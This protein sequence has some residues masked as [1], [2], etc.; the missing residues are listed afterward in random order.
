MISPK[1]ILVSNLSWASKSEEIALLTL[2]ELGIRYL[3]VAPLKIPGFTNYSDI[4]L[5]RNYK[6]FIFNN[7]GLKIYSVQAVLHRSG[8]SIFN[9][10]EE[11]KVLE[12]FIKI[13]VFSSE[14]GAKLLILGSPK[15]RILNENQSIEFT[16]DLVIKLI[17][18]SKMYDIKLLIEANPVQYGTNFLVNYDQVYNY[19]K[20]LA[21]NRNILL[22]VILDIGSMII[23]QEDLTDFDEVFISFIKHVH[24]SRPFLNGVEIDDFTKRLITKLKSKGYTGKF[25]VESLE[26]KVELLKKHLI[27]LITT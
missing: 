5:A 24:I 17:N 12:Y 3:E 22:E 1:D 16:Y 8:L 21:N 26:I 6:N 27:E 7:Y 2:N 9:P 18:I 20:Y 23:N 11:T 25:S 4:E 15:S 13:F 14:L 10:F 19:V